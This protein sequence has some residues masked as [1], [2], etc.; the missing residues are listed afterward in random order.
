MAMSMASCDLYQKFVDFLTPEVPITINKLAAGERARGFAPQQG[1]GK[2]WRMVNQEVSL[3]A[4]IGTPKFEE[5]V[6]VDIVITTTIDWIKPVMCCVGTA[7]FWIAGYKVMAFNIAVSGATNAI[8]TYM[9]PPRHLLSLRLEERTLEQSI[10]HARFAL[11]EKGTDEATASVCI[12]NRLLANAP[13]DL[14]NSTF[15]SRQ[16]HTSAGTIVAAAYLLGALRMTRSTWDKIS[17]AQN[18]N[19]KRDIGADPDD[20]HTAEP[21][22]QNT[23]PT[24]PIRDGVKYMVKK[25]DETRDE[26][27]KVVY[28]TIP[29]TADM[30]AITPPL[31]ESMNNEISALYR[32]ARPVPPKTD[33]A[34]ERLAKAGELIEEFLLSNMDALEED[35]PHLPR[36]WSEA[37]KERAFVGDPEQ[38]AKYGHKQTGMVKRYEV[39]IK[40]NK[41]SRGIGYKDKQSTAFA[42]AAIHPLEQIVHK[43]MKKF[44]FKYLSNEARIEEMGRWLHAGVQAGGGTNCYYSD[45]SQF[46]NSIT[47]QDKVWETKLTHTILSRCMHMLGFATEAE[48]ECLKFGGAF[49]MERGR[50]KVVW[51]MK[52]LIVYIDGEEVWRFSGERGTSI[53]NLLQNIRDFLA[54]VI[55]ARGLVYARAVLFDTKYD[56]VCAMKGDGDDRTARYPPDFYK[57]AEDMAERYKDLGRL[58]EPVRTR[59]TET[60]VVSW[61]FFLT[62]KDKEYRE[63]TCIGMPKPDKFFKNSQK[64]TAAVASVHIDRGDIIWC[65][66]LHALAATSLLTIA[67]DSWMCPLTAHWCAAWARFHVFEAGENTSTMVDKGMQRAFEL[68]LMTPVEKTLAA[69]MAR[70]MDKISNPP[71]SA[72]VLARKTAQALTHEKPVAYFDKLAEQLEVTADL[73]S[74]WTPGWGDFASP[75]QVLESVHFGVAIEPLGIV[76]IGQASDVGRRTSLDDV[77][78]VPPGLT[79]MSGKQAEFSPGKGKSVAPKGTP[80]EPTAGG[81]SARTDSAKGVARQSKK[82]AKGRGR[83][84][85]A[86]LG[87]AAQGDGA[88]GCG[89]APNSTPPPESV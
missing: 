76:R 28:T 71:F 82:T 35:V 40:D 3:L 37:E 86:R 58:L 52:Y 26:E 39:G 18:K 19:D 36:S 21:D 63:G 1:M 66:E 30:S 65:A 12:T 53:H 17:D 45:Y 77:A 2:L 60:E 87:L 22:R 85:G 88:R 62:E 8:Y 55:R 33:E 67:E 68:G 38:L 13:S 42:A 49:E 57:N 25:P 75:K 64:Q 47:L 9:F 14:V 20:M 72:K 11:G 81:A 34:K 31:Q 5:P 51:D 23:A 29:R 70:V 27:D 6:D 44:H 59:A 50:L 15:Q 89:G 73:L 84:N 43:R 32:H 4:E 41:P 74:G 54:E 24:G 48:A 83:G 69:M 80:V 56:K 10:R 78:S 7:V 16:Y 46:D 79:T 61:W